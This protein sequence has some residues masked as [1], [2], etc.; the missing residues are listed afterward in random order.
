MVAERGGFCDAVVQTEHE[1]LGEVLKEADVLY[2]TRMQK[3]RFASRE[4]THER[5]L[6]PGEKSRLFFVVLVVCYTFLKC[7][8]FCDIAQHNRAIPLCLLMLVL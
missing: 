7:L 5:G 6:R 4:V 8:C 2:I 3:E 1:D